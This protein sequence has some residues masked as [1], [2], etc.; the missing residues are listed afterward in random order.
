MLVG[1]AAAIICRVGNTFEIVSCLLRMAF[2]PM[3]LAT[4]LSMPL[5]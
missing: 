4:C 1:E 5:K 2:I 3:D